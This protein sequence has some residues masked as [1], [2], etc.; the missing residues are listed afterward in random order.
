MT[1][2]PKGLHDELVERLIKGSTVR[3]NLMSWPGYAPYCLDC[4][5]VHRLTWTPSL[6]QFKCGSCGF[7]TTFPAE[8]IAI[9][10]EKWNK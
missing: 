1:F 10:K 8:F 9:Y 4:S 5:A 7:T 6:D 2:F 3:R